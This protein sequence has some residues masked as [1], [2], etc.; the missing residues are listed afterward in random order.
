MKIVYEGEYT[1]RWYDSDTHEM[2]RERVYK[3]TIT[4]Y[5]RDALVSKGGLTLGRTLIYEKPT[6]ANPKPDPVYMGNSAISFDNPV[7]P[8]YIFRKR[9]RA[10][11]HDKD[12]RNAPVTGKTFYGFGVA[13]EDGGP[14]LDKWEEHVFSKVILTNEEEHFYIADNEYLDVIYTIIVIPS[15]SDSVGTY[16]G[17]SYRA[18]RAN[19]DVPP[20]TLHGEDVAIPM[21]RN[22]LVFETQ[23]LG[24]ITGRPSGDFYP[25]VPED[26]LYE[27]TVNNCTACLTIP[28]FQGN[29]PTGTI[30]SIVTSSPYWNIRYQISFD[31]PLE[32]T[33]ENMLRIN[34]TTWFSI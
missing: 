1:L 17:G 4:T 25:V 9:K 14:T 5:G 30:G 16:P 13:F 2:K 32:K 19:I 3:N 15:T 23:E 18:R 31:P 11:F 10:R 12:A 34:L 28:Y 8:N 6:L 22:F 7:A 29:T 26:V 20:A 21:V 27:K 33:D 24:A